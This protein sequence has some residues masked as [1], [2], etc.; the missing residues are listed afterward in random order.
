[1]G[2]SSPAHSPALRGR[3]LKRPLPSLWSPS[4]GS[5][6]LEA[7]V[8]V[9]VAAAGTVELGPSF[10]RDFC[11]RL[12]PAVTSQRAGP[13]AAMVAKDYPFYLTVKRA[14]CSLEAPLG[15]GAA[16]DEV[17][18][19]LHHL[20]LPAPPPP[21]PVYCSLSFHLPCVLRFSRLPLEMFP[22]QVFSVSPLSLPLSLRPG[23][24]APRRCLFPARASVSV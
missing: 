5:T 15:S 7:A 12:A 10:T 24:A 18:R 13:A 6:R 4:V 3:V 14:N 16:K 20:H 21:Y 1:M 22:S 11:C 8:G 2:L 9:R 17:G 19:A 23:T